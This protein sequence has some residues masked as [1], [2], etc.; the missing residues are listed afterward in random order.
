MDNAAKDALAQKLER[1]E[2]LVSRMAKLQEIIV[3]LEAMLESRLP[4][5]IMISPVPP[6]P[7]LAAQQFGPPLPGI[8]IDVGQSSAGGLSFDTFSEAIHALSQTLASQYTEA[9]AQYAE[10]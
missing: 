2:Y 5:N 7:T 6:S 8:T 4:L 3:R 10:L 9:Q 1:A